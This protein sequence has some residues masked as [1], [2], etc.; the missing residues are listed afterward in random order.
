M[1][2]AVQ[3]LCKKHVEDDITGTLQEFGEGK[4]SKDG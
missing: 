1:P 3:L 2:L 4:K